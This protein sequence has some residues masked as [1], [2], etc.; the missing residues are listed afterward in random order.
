MGTR[1]RMLLKK[2]LYETADLTAAA[3]KMTR[4]QSDFFIGMTVNN[5]V[6]FRDNLA[7]TR[8]VDHRQ[9]RINRIMFSEPVT[10]GAAEGVEV[11]RTVKPTTSYI[12]YTTSK[13]TSA[14]DRTTELMEEN[15]EGEAFEDTIAEEF[16]KRMGNDF[17]LLAILGDTVKYAADGSATGLLLKTMDGWFKQAAGANIVDLGG[18]TVSK[19]VFSDMI[20]TMPNHYKQN[21]AGL[22]FYVS[23]GIA[24][25][26]RD[27]LASRNTDLGDASLVGSGPLNAYGIPI[28]EVPLFPQD[29][30]SYDGSTNYDN[31]TFAWLTFPE[32]LIRVISR[33]IEVYKEFKPRFDKWEWTLYTYQGHYIQ[34]LEAMVMGVNLRLQ[35]AQ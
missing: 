29:L 4:T 3:G 17:E 22:R 32:N 19:V 34:N 13:L 7:V 25:D 10:Y 28:V 18:T 23:P 30:D 26:W 11:T 2:S 9:G 31:A 20:R 33:D 12:D 15:V 27:Q 35:G 21:R 24:Q 5:S 6:L 1:Q 8:R 14:M 16:A